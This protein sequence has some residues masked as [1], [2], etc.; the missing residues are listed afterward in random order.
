V[1]VIDAE[2]VNRVVLTA[3]LPSNTPLTTLKSA[4]FIPGAWG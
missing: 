3:M 1:V 4:Q 2:V